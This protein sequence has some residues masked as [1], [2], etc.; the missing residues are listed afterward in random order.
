MCFVLYCV[1]W[2]DDVV[3]GIYV[4]V[5]VEG[6]EGIFKLRDSGGVVVGSVMGD[7][8]KVVLDVDIFE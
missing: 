8:Y 7:V 1:G 2:S 6:G 5:V 3:I 4:C